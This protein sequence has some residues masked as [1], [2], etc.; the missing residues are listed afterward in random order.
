MS[1]IKKKK[2]PQFKTVDEESKFWEK[3]DS[4]DYIDW[5]ES[6]LASFPDLKQSATTI[7]LRLR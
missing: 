6:K 1:N 7:S 5:N 3:T 2:L 4:T